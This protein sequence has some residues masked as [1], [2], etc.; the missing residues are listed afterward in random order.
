VT[1]QRVGYGFDAHRFG[2]QGPVV[3][4]GVSVDH[5]VGVLATSDGDVAAHAVCDAI[6]GAA[7]LGDVGTWFPSADPQWSDARSLDL[8]SRCV[9]MVFDR[10][11]DIANVDVTIVVQDIRVSPRRDAMREALASA[12]RLPLTNVSI[13]ATTTDGLGWIGSG[14]GLAAHAVVIL[15]R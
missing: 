2:G 7:A 1:E 8:V 3:L 10:G 12:M 4:C 9:T 11:Y 14:D 6:L 13:K 5:P 15:Q